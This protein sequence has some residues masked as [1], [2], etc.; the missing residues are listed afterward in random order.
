MIEPIKICRKFEDAE[1]WFV[2]FSRHRNCNLDTDLDL[3]ISL[4]WALEKL[5]CT[6]TVLPM[7]APTNETARSDDQTALSEDE[8]HALLK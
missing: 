4:S 2:C 3:F 8:S 5:G 1:E 7:P 6:L